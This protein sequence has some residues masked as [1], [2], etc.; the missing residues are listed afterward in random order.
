MTS[1]II[2]CYRPVLGQLAGLCSHVL[3]DGAKVI[4][5]DNTELP[6]LDRENFPDGCSLITLGYNSGIA[7]AQNVGIAAAL[8]AGATVVAFFDQ[9]SKIAPGLLHHLVSAVAVGTPEI[10][11]PLYVD[12]VT[13]IA[14]PSVR[15]SWYGWPMRVHRAHSC[16]RYPVDIVISSGTVAT[17]EV[18]DLA[19]T[20]DDGLF[21]D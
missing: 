13:G 20:F 14:L 9:D 18:F 3:G 2:V 1:C 19:G 5:V 11:A 12:E 21:I 7:H 8:A 16:S 4:V 17:R 10:V 6:Y 15:L